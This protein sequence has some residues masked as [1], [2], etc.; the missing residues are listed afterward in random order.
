MTTL[1]HCA[2][3]LIAVSSLVLENR[4]SAAMQASAVVLQ[5]G[6][7]SGS[8]QALVCTGS[9]V[10]ACRRGCSMARG[11]FPD[12]RG[13]PC[14]CTG[15]I[16]THCTSREVYTDIIFETNF[17]I[18]MIKFICHS[19]SVIY[20]IWLLRSFLIFWHVGK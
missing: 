4:L 8:V 13:N 19:Q 1:H 20:S 10:V 5:H 2:R 11:I 12:L 6:I 9:V 15:R 16:L 14:P 3:L 7:H 18:I 17:I